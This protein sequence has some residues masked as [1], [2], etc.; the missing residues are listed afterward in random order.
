MALI[1]PSSAITAKVRSIYGKRLKLKDYQNMAKCE[2]I[3]EIMQYLKAYTHYREPLDKISNYVHRGNLESTL[4]EKQFEKY[5]ALCKYCSG[6][7]PVTEYYLRSCEITELMRKITLL[8]I[9]RPEEYI[10]ALP[11]YF[12][13]HTELDLEAMSTAHSHREL[14]EA[15]SKTEYQDIVAQFPPNEIG[16]YNLAAVEDALIS[17][18][19]KKLYADFGK[20]KNKKDRNQLKELFDTLIDYSNYTRIIR[21]KKYYNLNNETV[22]SHLLGYGSLAGKRLDR[23]LSKEELSDIREE[24]SRTSVG[25]KAATIDKNSEMAVQGRF[26]KCRHELYFSTNPE[27]IMLAFYILSETELSNLI[28][29]IEGVRYKTPP[30]DILA[31][32]IM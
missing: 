14:L 21:L 29:V 16:D 17:Y 22:R 26:N 12:M 28:A 31:L 32:L 27:I 4:R 30:E 7:S 9:N 24:L 19:L 23:I 8:S 2:S 20:I 18:S 10:F 11:L 15:L 1:N 6:F 3:S 25:K 5:L 13:R